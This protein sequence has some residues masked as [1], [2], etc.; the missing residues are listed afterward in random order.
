MEVRLQVAGIGGRAV[1][2][3]PDRHVGAKKVV[4]EGILLENRIVLRR[5]VNRRPAHRADKGYDV[6]TDAAP[7][8]L[9]TGM[10]LTAVYS[11]MLN[12]P[13]MFAPLVRNSRHF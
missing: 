3:K 5:L 7:A 10:P 1:G 9:A 13:T 8:G 4:A 2:L 11:G 6:V 12:K